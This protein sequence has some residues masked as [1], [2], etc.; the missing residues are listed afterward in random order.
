MA[1]LI[2]VEEVASYL[3]VTKRTIYRLLKRGSVSGDQSGPT[4]EV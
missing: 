4:V 3:R 1:E 2:T